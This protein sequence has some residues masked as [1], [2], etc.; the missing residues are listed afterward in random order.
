MVKYFVQNFLN[1]LQCLGNKLYVCTLHH[2][3]KA[4]SEKTGKLKWRKTV[5]PT[6]LWSHLDLCTRGENVRLSVMSMKCQ[7]QEEM[8]KSVDSRAAV[9]GLQ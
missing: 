5:F 6:N 7:Q 9:E 8:W 3:Y 2:K 1:N 4:Y